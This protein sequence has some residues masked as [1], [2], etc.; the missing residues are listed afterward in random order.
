MQPLR[1][2]WTEKA[3]SADHTLYSQNAADT[4]GLAMPKVELPERNKDSN[5]PKKHQPVTATRRRWWPGMLL[6][7]V[8][9]V[10]LLPSALSIFGQVPVILKRV[11]PRLANIVSF[12][13][14]HLHWWA[15]VEISGLEVR[16]VTT[17]HNAD[18]PGGM[19][20]FVEDGSPAP[21]KSVLPAKSEE[22]HSLLVAR[23][24]RTQEPLW[25]IVAR[26]GGGI[27]YELIE[28]ELNL[29]LDDQG[30]NLQRTLQAVAGRTDASEEELFAIRVM[31]HDG[32]ATL[33]S[34]IS[35]ASDSPGDN[36]PPDSRAVT[37]VT[38]IN[39]TFS[40]LD[41]TC[42]L[43]ELQL[44]AF[45]QRDSKGTIGRS[46]QKQP[47]LPFAASSRGSVNPRLAA[48]LDE[49]TS[50]FSMSPLQG[51][52][53]PTGEDSSTSNESIV[54]AT[55]EGRVQIAIAAD[56]QNN[57]R[58][59]VRIAARQLDLRLLHPLLSYYSPDL[60]CDGEV[61]CNIQAELAGRT[62][63][64]GVVGRFLLE[65]QQVRLRQ[66][67]WMAGEWLNLG[68]TSA[69]GAAA[70][71]ADGLLL[72]DITMKSDVMSVTGNGE[73]RHV[74]G[75]P[76]VVSEGDEHKSLSEAMLSSATSQSLSESNSAELKGSVDI[77]SVAGMLPGTLSLRENV[78]FESGQLAFGIR[79]EIVNAGP[80]RA[81]NVVRWQA[82][83]QND[84][85]KA[86]QAGR[87]ITLDSTLRL[88]AVGPI[89][90]GVPAVT[91]ARVTGE[92][93]NAFPP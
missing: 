69:A 62:L 39:G 34:L 45:I 31:V 68:K 87:Y 49:L 32:R 76:S 47:S 83:V 81:E 67:S 23:T 93:G 1:H 86:T 72:K 43:P 22:R 13:T 41:S 16:D 84:G 6:V 8:I 57:N 71:A 40:T 3:T 10:L 85:I 63:T 88:D 38:G 20:S 58:Q 59:S 91:Q 25:K 74:A 24:V 37:Y 48:N 27:S 33:R 35:T 61:S 65:G 2:D 19:N 15:P 42:A 64:D 75:S 60:V 51:L 70:V 90:H 9:T 52:D 77:A 66:S 17:P 28:P 36:T 12:R 55:P 30:S 79:G 92:F 56:S 7:L 4:G 21:D 73:L 14:I 29:I 11:H 5:E 54:A 50:E 26:L 89:I 44:Q 78:R 18:T 82:F 46:D 53:V 80:G